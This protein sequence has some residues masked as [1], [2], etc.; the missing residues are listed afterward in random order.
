MNSILPSFR[1]RLDR[2]LLALALV[3]L[4]LV[5]FL[6]FLSW[7]RF[8]QAIAEG[9][10][11]R[12]V[13]EST[14]GLITALKD[15]EGAMRLFI[16]TDN[17]GDLAEYEAIVKTIPERKQALA[18]VPVS[19]AQ[20]VIVGDI[21]RLADQRVGLMETVVRIRQR[22]TLEAAID[23]VQTGKGQ[24]TMEEVRRITQQLLGDEYDAQIAMAK[25]AERRAFDVFL[26]VM[27][28]CAA[29]F[30]ILLLL[31]RAADRAIAQRNAAIRELE[32]TGQR[33]EITLS[34]I[35]DGVI[36]TDRDSR[37]TFLNPVAE[38]LT[39]WARA[40]A[41]GRPSEEVF[42][43]ADEAT[44]ALRVSPLQHVL[45][46]GTP[47]G[48]AAAT[49]LLPKQGG[50]VPIADLGSP[51]RTENGEIVGAVLVF[52]DIR[53]T[54]EAQRQ[55][56]KWH[57]L[58]RAGGFGMAVIDSVTGRLLDLNPAFAQMH[59]YEE[60]EL[61]GQPYSLLLAHSETDLRGLRESG[62][63]TFESLHVRKD[64]QAFPVLTDMTTFH[65]TTGKTT[66]RAAYFSDISARILAERVSRHSEERFKTAVK[67]VGDII[68]TN[69]PEGCMVGEQHAWSSFTGQSFEQY[70]GFSWAEALHPADYERTLATWKHAVASG[71]KF[72]LEHRVRRYD[73]V[74]RL[75]SVRALPL[76]DD[77]GQ[78]R[79]WVGVHADITDERENRDRLRESEARFRGLATALPQVIWSTR[80]DGQFEYTNPAWDAYLGPVP[81]DPTKLWEQA[82]HPDDSSAV[83]PKWRAATAAKLPL[84]FQA[85]LKCAS[86]G[87]FRTFLCRSVPLLDAQGQLLRWFGSCTDV[88]EQSRRSGELKA[89]NESLR[90]SNT[91][92][93][94]FAY[95]ASH[96]LQEP[97]RMVALYTQLLGEEYSQQLDDGARFYIDQSKKGALR[98]EALLRDL[99]TYALVTTSAESTESRT[100]AN[101]AVRDALQNLESL[102][103]RT[104]A[105]IPHSELPTVYIPAVRLIQ[106]FQNL[107][108]NSLKYRRE[109]VP[110]EVLIAALPQGPDQWLFSV[111]D[112]GI[113]I[114]PQYI[115]QIFG[116]FKRI[117]GPDYEG[118]GIG[119]AICQ[120]I[121]ENAGGRIWVESEVN[122]GTTFFFTLPGRAK[123]TR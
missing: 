46:T 47:E 2:G 84:E 66:E 34:S 88:D 11:S 57:G 87:S 77:L 107:I 78:V 60:S 122:R 116:I 86:D 100:D 99:L 39:G 4:G 23:F 112:N 97:L 52:R 5:A 81:A 96:D 73:G 27:I 121:V 64:G 54:R 120:R 104:G 8:E 30:V 33:W 3:I 44:G 117:H 17:S 91:D 40:D 58:F 37:V 71:Q 7:R 12:A 92:L 95:A 108:G 114:P 111:Q 36:A 42:R 105:S 85:R 123:A 115:D 26:V 25:V 69:S 82:I 28:G 1:R 10:R 102:I 6:S 103:V 19:P 21:L 50:E 38:M 41:A 90:R 32:D 45:K 67:V 15:A 16:L 101:V 89:S 76:F 118:T 110:P 61:V 63:F 119:L 55:I 24:A 9:L 113:G 80:P 68:W 72:V 83:L 22:E 35:A 18:A 79:E 56:E 51:I 31:R 75:F 106:L 70:Q 94:Q 49:L 29:A 13:L 98:M 59:G 53:S 48:F 93:E 20:G 65:D 14:G 62:Q 109:S 74:Y 43:I